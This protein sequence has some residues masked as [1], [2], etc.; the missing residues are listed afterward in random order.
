MN[1]IKNLFLK[2]TSKNNYKFGFILALGLMVLCL[3]P[4]AHAQIIDPDFVNLD[5]PNLGDIGK[6]I[7][8]ISRWA[9]GVIGGIVIVVIMYGGFQYVTGVFEG[10][11]DNED[12]KNT[13]KNGIIGLFIVLLSYTVISFIQ[14]VMT[15]DF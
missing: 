11:E 12:A 9:A 5:D 8:S 6:M 14:T 10:K 3:H 4:P 15:T 1:F 2:I 7:L 13:I